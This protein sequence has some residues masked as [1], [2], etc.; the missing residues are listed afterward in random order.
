M[1]RLSPRHLRLPTETPR[2][3]RVSVPRASLAPLSLVHPLMVPPFLA[4]ETAWHMMHAASNTIGMT[5]Q[6]ASFLDLLRAATVEPQQVIAALTS[7]DLADTTLAQLKGTRTSLSP[8]PLPPQPPR[9]ILLLQK[10][11]QM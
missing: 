2:P 1:A 3:G 7:V 9:Q 11:F 4:P 8:L 6:V 10:P 5:Q